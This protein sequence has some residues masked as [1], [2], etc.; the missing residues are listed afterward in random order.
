MHEQ[1]PV[2]LWQHML[3]GTRLFDLFTSG[4]SSGDPSM[5]DPVLKRHINERMRYLDPGA[6][7]R[8]GGG[9]A[10]GGLAATIST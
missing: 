5:V 2:P 3:V 8:G 7:R 6:M 10:T 1:R 9:R 4:Q